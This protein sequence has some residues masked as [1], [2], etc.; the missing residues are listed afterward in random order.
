VADPH[1]G[2]N[3]PVTT[4]EPLHHNRDFVHLWAAQT[5]SFF[6]TTFGALA[7]TALIFLDATP[8]QMGILAMAQ[9]MPVLLFALAAGVLVDRLPRRPVLIVADVGRFGALLTV[10]ASALLDALV[11]E[12][13]Y[14]VAFVV[15][16]LDLAFQV[17]YRSYLPAL[18]PREQ[19]LAANARLSATESVA[20][21]GSAAGGLIVQIA[22]GPIAVLVDAFT[23]LVSGLLVKRIRRPEPPIPP[24]PDAS[25]LREARAGVGVVVRNPV[26]RALTGSR[27]SMSFFGAFIGALYSL[28][29][30]RELGFSPFVM[31]LTIAAGGL[32][33]IGGALIVGS[34]TRRL[35]IGPTLLFSSLGVQTWL[36]PLAGGPAELALLMILISQLFGDPFW[37]MYEIGSVSLRQS[38]THER[39]L[40]RVSSTMHLVEAGLIPIGALTAGILAE[41]IGVRETLGIAAIG[42]TSA[43]LWIVLSPIPRLRDVPVLANGP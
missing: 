21:S 29:L 15:G 11:I 6:G 23:F 28:F 12:Q 18:V 30:I 10:P 24:Q 19:L 14:L 35:G 33:S 3:A 22:S 34:V 9:G 4:A 31:G 17:A 8:G 37:T 7:L 38:V 1:I 40:G 32:G 20:E 13:L 16:A 39:M 26:L 25:M 36:I 27:A 2:S 43:A 42:V 5:V 41:A